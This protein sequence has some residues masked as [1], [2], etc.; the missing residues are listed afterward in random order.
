MSWYT[1]VD[2][3]YIYSEE[4]GASPEFDLEHA[5]AGIELLVAGN[6]YHHHVAQDICD[7]VTKKQATFKLIS[8]AVIEL[9]S[10]LATEYPEV[11]FAVR[12]RGEDIRDVWLRE[13]AG[14]KNILAL[15]PPEGASL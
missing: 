10:K 7:L 9:F 15:G 3:D 11:S 1:F 14:G 5:R 2:F 12:G 8:Y 4:H 13:Y 6:K